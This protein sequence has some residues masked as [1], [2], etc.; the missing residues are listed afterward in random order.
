MTEYHFSWGFHRFHAMRLMQNGKSMVSY[1]DSI[2]SSGKKRIV[3]G[4][5]YAFLHY[6]NINCSLGRIH[7]WKSLLHTFDQTPSDLRFFLMWGCINQNTLKTT[8]F[9]VYFFSSNSTSFHVFSHRQPWTIPKS[10]AFQLSEM[11]V[12]YPLPQK[13]MLFRQGDFSKLSYA[14]S[15]TIGFPL[16]LTLDNS[17]GSQR[18]GTRHLNCTERRVRWVTSLQAGFMGYI[19]M[20]WYYICNP[21]NQLGWSSAV[22]VTTWIYDIICIYGHICSLAWYIYRYVTYLHGL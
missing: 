14:I 11:D 5:H 2:H 12:L 1:S 21:W 15:E 4:L 16:V 20:I 3:F 22:Y 8:L 18:P 13:A 10:L 7:G 17:L 19:W 9:G 6:I